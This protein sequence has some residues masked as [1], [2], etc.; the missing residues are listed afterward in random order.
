[1]DVEEQK[2]KGNKED[3]E[4]RNCRLKWHPVTVRMFRRKVEASFSL[5]ENCH[6]TEKLEATG[7]CKE[8]PVIPV[9]KVVDEKRIMAEE[10]KRHKGSLTL[11]ANIEKFLR[12]EQYEY[13]R[14]R[15]L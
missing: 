4:E 3:R 7:R 14:M 15:T 5:R 1:M 12:I 6:E 9:N 8:M 10:E 13:V 11:E 2:K